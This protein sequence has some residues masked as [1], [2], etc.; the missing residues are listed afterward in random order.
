M[1]PEKENVATLLKNMPMYRRY[2]YIYGDNNTAI[3]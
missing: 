3:M 2:K 1:Q